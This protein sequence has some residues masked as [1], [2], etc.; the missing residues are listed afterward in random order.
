MKHL[1]IKIEK[2]QYD[3]SFAITGAIRGTSWET[4]ILNLA[5]NPSNLGNGSE[6]WLVFIKF[7]LQD[8]VS[9]YFN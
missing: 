9:I 8:Y 4:S 3:A 7:S 2:T 1:L 5:M 6:N